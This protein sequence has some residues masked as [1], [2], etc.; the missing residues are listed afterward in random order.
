MTL[1]KNLFRKCSLFIWEEIHREKAPMHWS[2]PCMSTNTPEPGQRPKLRGRKS[3]RSPTLVT[4]TQLFEPSRLP[5]RTCISSKLEK[6]ARA[7]LSNPSTP[8]GDTRIP[9]SSLTT[10]SNVYPLW[11]LSRYNTK[12]IV[13][14][15]VIVKIGLRLKTSVY[16][17]HRQCNEKIYKD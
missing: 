9:I 17:R 10:R 2:I 11:L 13:H 14:E 1:K 5:P 16:K 7:R 4:D 12:Y 6:G 15:T 8:L 3:I